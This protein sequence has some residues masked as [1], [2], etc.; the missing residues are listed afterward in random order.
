[1]TNVRQLLQGIDEEVVEIPDYLAV[2]LELR[3]GVVTDCLLI[4]A[5]NE[6]DAANSLRLNDT[7]Y[8][9]AGYPETIEKLNKKGF[10]IKTL[11]ISELIKAEAGLTCSSII[12]EDFGKS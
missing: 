4:V 2:I 12:F 11:D 1:M 8:L 6:Q 9:H 5:E 3:D 10:T 7:V